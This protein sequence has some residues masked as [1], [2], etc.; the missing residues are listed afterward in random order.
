MKV[1]LGIKGTSQNTGMRIDS[2]SV[3]G[4]N[5]HLALEVML[6]RARKMS[7]YHSVILIDGEI[8]V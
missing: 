2:P 3:R 1:L 4:E 8:I 7:S 6:D 5:Q